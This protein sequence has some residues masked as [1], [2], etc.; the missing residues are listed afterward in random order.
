MKDLIKIAYI[1]KKEYEHLCLPAMQQFNITRSELDIIL[2]L[3]NNPELDSA[4]DIVEKRGLSKSHASLGVEMLVQKGYL[5]QK[6]DE[7]DRR[8]YH[9][10]LQDAALPIAR[11]GAAVQQQF[12]KM[13]FEGLNEEEIAL[14]DQVQKKIYQ[15]ILRKGEC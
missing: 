8:R 15:N 13:I 5:I 10:L 3:Y 6:Q 9:L 4:K 11:A 2:F 12:A 1:M 7:K 14:F